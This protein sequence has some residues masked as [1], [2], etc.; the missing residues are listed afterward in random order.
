V[1]ISSWTNKITTKELP[2]IYKIKIESKIL[3]VGQLA[4][5]CNRH[6]TPTSLDDLQVLASEFDSGGEDLAFRFFISTTRI[7]AQT[8][9][10][11]SIHAAA[12]YKLL[13]EG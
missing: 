1:S 5:I 6:K 9:G 4:E 8:D 10:A 12:T 11:L 2:K 7:L 13:W 3:S